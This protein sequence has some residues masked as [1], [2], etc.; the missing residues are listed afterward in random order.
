MAPRS[1]HS[2]ESEGFSC[3]TQALSSGREAS[4]ELTWPLN[5]SV[6]AIATRTLLDV[7]SGVAAFRAAGGANGGSRVSGDAQIEFAAL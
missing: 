3:R 1:F 6:G 5:R 4:H 2:A 7:W